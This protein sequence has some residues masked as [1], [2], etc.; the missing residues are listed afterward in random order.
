ME[1]P[2]GT[3]KEQWDRYEA[4]LK[5]HNE[6]ITNYRFFLDRIIKH[7]EWS[8]SKDYEWSVKEIKYAIENEIDKASS[9][10][11]PNKPGCLIA[12]ND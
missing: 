11:A 1:Y 12:N 10:D 7:L 5:D 6:F 3:T 2:K 4:E 9:M 8:A